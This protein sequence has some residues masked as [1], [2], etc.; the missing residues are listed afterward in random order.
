LVVS[1]GLAFT[2]SVPGHPGAGARPLLGVPIDTVHLLAAAVWVGGLVMMAAVGRG[3]VERSGSEPV[4]QRF[5]RWALIAVPV[6]VITGAAQTVRL[7]DRVSALTD[8]SWGRVLLVK[9][10][11]VVVAVAV[12]AVA[13]WLLRADGPAAIGRLVVAEVVLGLVIVSLAA[14]LVALPPQ[15]SAEV[16]PFSATVV[17]D[18]LLMEVAVTPARP[19]PNELHLVF[20]PTGGSLQQVRAARAELSLPGRD[21][22]AIDVELAFAGPNHWS[23][24]I[25]I[26]YAGDW[27]LVVDVDDA[28]GTA[29]RFVVAVPIES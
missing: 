20:V 18:G 19:G 27:S 6:L 25:R 1:I 11:V 26:P 9:V 7:A 13:H 2:F 8:T 22:P 15:G 12:G 17:S 5:S 28:T 21:T 10:T 4:L 16:S 29:R 3:W 23:A 14:G 24:P